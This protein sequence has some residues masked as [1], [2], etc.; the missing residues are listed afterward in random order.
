MSD[1]ALK[2]CFGEPVRAL[3]VL[4]SPYGPTIYAGGGKTLVEQL[5]YIASL[6]A[7]WSVSRCAENCS[8]WVK[9][10]ARSEW[11]PA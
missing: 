7:I 2:N 4:P 3:V 8:V 5:R 10:T 9:P 6:Q 11:E 1:N